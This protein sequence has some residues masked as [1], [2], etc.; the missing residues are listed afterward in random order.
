MQRL[1]PPDYANGVGAPRVA[2]DGSPLAS[3]RRISRLVFGNGGDVMRGAH[4]HCSQMI[5]LWAQFVYADLV[6]IG[7][8]RLFK[9]MQP[10]GSTNCMKFLKG[11]ESLPL[12]C[13][14]A[15]HPEC[16]PITSDDDDFAYKC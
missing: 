9:G 2:R 7:S 10:I 5:A 11:N 13:C 8:T 6:H 16:M 15:P 1:L 4:R 3:A 12:P 14:A